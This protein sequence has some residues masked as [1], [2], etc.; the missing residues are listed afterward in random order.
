MAV[1]EDD[2]YDIF[3][4]GYVE[5]NYAPAHNFKQ[6]DRENVDDVI[7]Y[8]GYLQNDTRLSKHERGLINAAL[9]YTKWK[10]VQENTS[11]KQYSPGFASVSL[12][13][14]N[15]QTANSTAEFSGTIADAD[16]FVYKTLHNHG[17]CIPPHF[18][19]YRPSGA[20]VQLSVVVNCTGSELVTAEIIKNQTRVLCGGHCAYP[21]NYP[22]NGLIPVGYRMQTMDNSPRP[23][24]FYQLRFKGKGDLNVLSGRF[25]I[26]Y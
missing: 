5:R 17:F 22:R 23:S 18:N 11:Q 24:D 16:K 1:I 25:E 10:Y 8:L 9:V 26:N 2:G 3:R 21:P 4:G 15:Y 12:L 19:L 20:Q 13:Q 6:Y 7:S 14:G